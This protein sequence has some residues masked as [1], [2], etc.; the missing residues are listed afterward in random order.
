MALHASPRSG[1]SP[2]VRGNRP[3]AGCA[4]PPCQGLSPRVRGNPMEPA[5]QSRSRSIPA[6]TGEPRAVRN[7]KL[8]AGVYPRVYG[9]TMRSGLGRLRGLSPRVRGNPSLR[10]DSF[11]GSDG[12]LSPRVRGNP[13]PPSGNDPRSIAG[14][15]PR[16]RG[17]LCFTQFASRKGSIP[18]CTGEP[19]GWPQR[20]DQG[21][22][23]RVRGNRASIKPGRLATVYPRVYG[24]TAGRLRSALRR[25]GSIPA[26]TGEPSAHC[27]DM[28]LEQGLSPRVRGNRFS[29]GGPGKPC[30]AVYPRVYGGTL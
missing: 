7:A 11:M 18:A 5:E 10:T 19:G 9:G 29:R 1:L 21:L 2:R 13:P 30:A 14:L 20:S 27:F 16:V 4:V 22:S 12:G 15:S 24:G 3:A 8:G 23:P 17:N 26:C 25:D 6:C 28:P